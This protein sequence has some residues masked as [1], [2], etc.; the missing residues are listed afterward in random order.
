M[1]S[2]KEFILEE[3]S[4]I[5]VKNLEVIFVT[6][7]ENLLIQV[8]DNYN[9]DNISLYLDDNCLKDMPS[10]IKNA[11]ELFGEEN[12]QN[13]IDAYFEYS[14]MSVPQDAT[15]KPDL[16]WDKRYDNKVDKN[17]N[18]VLYSLDNFQYKIL[19]DEFVISNSLDKELEEIL[20]DIFLNA[21][22][23]KLHPWAFNIKLD[24]I[25]FDK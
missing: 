2:L 23:N 7:S 12:S 19:F 6:D 16:E 10:E 25:N 1:K 3:L 9:E 17:A 5:T 13:I 4:K 15:E 14:N 24:K 18:L 21:E 22:S 11:Q 20:K 8:P